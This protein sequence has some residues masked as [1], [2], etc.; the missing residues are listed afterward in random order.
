MVIY[1]LSVNYTH[2][3][4]VLLLFAHL[5][6]FTAGAQLVVTEPPFPQTEESVRIIF[7]AAEGS[8]GLE[9]YSGTVYA[10]TGVI[11]DQSNG[12][13]DW[14]YVKTNW[15]QNTSDT[16]M[17]LIG[18]DMHA[19]DIGPSVR[20]YYGVPAGEEILQIAFVFRSAAQV[21]G[22]WL[23][24]KTSSGGDIFVDV[25]SAA[26][27]FLIQVLR[28]T[29]STG[30]LEVNDTLDL[31]AFSSKRATHQ[32]FL[33][34]SLI[35]EEVD[36][37][38]I[39]A[40]YPID[41][42]GNIAMTYLAISE[43]DSLREEFQFIVPPPAPIAALPPGSRLG[44]HPIGSNAA[45]WVLEA[46]GKEQVW[47]QSSL[48]DWLL[49]TEGFQMNRTPGGRYFWIEQSGLDSGAFITYQYLIDGNIS[50]ADPLS[51]VVL[52]P[53]HDPF[54]G[55]V[56][57][58][59][60][61]YPD[62]ATGRVSLSKW[63]GFDYE[64]Q[65]G[66]PNVANEDM[67]IYELLIRDF[68]EDRSY[69]S[70]I[71]TLDYLERLGVNTI[72]LMPI[73]EFEGNISWGYNPSYHG[74]VDKYYGR[75]ED[76][77]AFI[78][79]AHERGMLVLLDV[80]YN[81]VFSQGPH[82]QMYWDATQ[83]RPSPENPW[84]NEEARHPFNVGYDYNH[85]YEGTTDYVKE[86]LKRWI[87]EYRFDGFRFDLSKGFT[88]RQSNDV[89]QWNQY[90]A[91][92]I[93]ILKDYADFIW[94]IRPETKA[95]LEHLGENREE[96]ELAEYGMLLWSKM[97]DPYNEATMGYNVNGQSDLSGTYFADRDWPV[98]HLVSYMESHDEERL[99]YKN[100][101]FGNRTSGHDTRD[102]NTA[103]QRIASATAFFYS[104]P[105]PKMLWQ[106]GELGYDFSINYCPDGSIN[107][108]CRT[109]PK[110][111]RWDYYEEMQ[112]FELWR[113][114][115]DM[116]D[117]KTQTDY[118]S[119]DR[120]VA[121][122][123]RG[124]IKRISIGDSVAVLGNFDIVERELS[125]NFR[126]LGTWY[127]YLTGDTIV[128]NQMN[129]KEFYAPGETRVYLKKPRP[130]PSDDLISSVW[131]FAIDSEVY[132]FPNPVRDQLTIHLTSKWNREA[133]F[134]GIYDMNGRV[135]HREQLENHGQT[136]QLDTQH[137]PAGT[138][139][140]ILAGDALRAYQKVV[141]P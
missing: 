59:L 9:G 137:W 21:N 37:T 78:D 106:F 16:R 131:D 19:L 45:R 86:T 20:E 126:T 39:N 31:L 23:E 80:V 25:F 17:S 61:E 4:F 96:L 98:P 66:F 85:E 30:I 58:G 54:I 18:E 13:S 7:D 89:F 1:Y 22:Q 52:D 83:F 111:I 138:F 134:L 114:T 116:I 56:W 113:T 64:F 76:L 41:S 82:A 100:Q 92:R 5:L 15:G 36:S 119:S 101:E 103:L 6:W 117:L 118:F 42:Q 95:I 53:A 87:E 128:V 84:L 120:D 62:E 132:V 109:G 75:P 121:L 94:N 50:I 47:L 127:D 10:H 74:A 139:Q 32:W 3:R 88:Q 72:E 123:V 65:N 33:N 51:E 26:D 34:G 24:G 133:V 107:N 130:R 93:A 110:P 125:H 81:H 90:D 27:D 77:K 38:V 129:R 135:I 40:N 12:A 73:Q 122:A 35:A 112:R 69:R 67:V 68:L 102:L 115:A 48:S 14:R 60:P 140:V 8:G 11:T 79:A 91:D 99:A 108:D 63:G 70:L 136:I 43:G 49:D 2:M 44:M 97:T 104:I 29:Q 141:K 57:P 55:D 46:P 71:D 105:G 28:P 124:A